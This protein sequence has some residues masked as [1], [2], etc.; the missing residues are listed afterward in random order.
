[1]KPLK[2]VMSAFGPYA[3]EQTID[4]TE[5]L[6]ERLFLITG[7]T[8]AGKTTIFDAISYALYGE[9]SGEMRTTDALRSHFSKPEDLT[10]VTLEFIL[11]EKRYIITRKPK[12]LRRK[13]KGEGFTE[14]KPEAV[15]YIY[16]TIY[17]SRNHTDD[18]SKFDT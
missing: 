1:M 8:G 11:K 6:S 14:Q 12:Q 7:P 2:L 16:N 5:L 18:E 3:K 15:L 13:T 10:E 4:F 17:E 9:S